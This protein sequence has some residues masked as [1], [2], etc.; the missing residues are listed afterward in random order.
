MTTG[1]ERTKLGRLVRSDLYRHGGLSGF[2]GFCRGW[3][4][5]GF[6]YSLL[7]RLRAAR[8]PSSPLS[9]FLRVMLRRY[10]FKY[11]FEINPQAEIGEGF[12]LT[13]HC[14]PVIIGP[15]KIG[16]LCTVAHN[17]TIGRTYD[18]QGGIGR[19]TLGDRVWMGA[20][21][22]LV[23]PITVGSDVLVA[24][25]AFVNFDVPDHSLVIGNPGRVVPRPDPTRFY[26]DFA[27]PDAGAPSSTRSEASGPDRTKPF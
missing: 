19:P 27:L 8:K 7:F 1:P 13:D 4:R 15:V 26:I 14:G 10:R 18:P 23:G 16:K 25:N 22:V 9:F 2:G 11:G 20:G 5:P 6:R 3:M 21:A 24:P 17:V 12:G